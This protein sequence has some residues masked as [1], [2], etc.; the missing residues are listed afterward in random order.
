MS[1]GLPL[2]L[3]HKYYFFKLGIT[4]S[5]LSNNFLA[6]LKHVFLASVI[7]NLLFKALHLK[8]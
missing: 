2:V 4:K 5:L 1:T 3:Y 8:K 7:A 6:M